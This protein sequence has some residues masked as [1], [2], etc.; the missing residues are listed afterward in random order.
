MRRDA[1]RRHARSGRGKIIGGKAIA[2]RLNFSQQRELNDST[3][4][5]RQPTV[6]PTRDLVCSRSTKKKRDTTSIPSL[7]D[8]YAYNETLPPPSLET[9]KKRWRPLGPFCIPHG[10]TYGSGPGCRPSISGRVSAIAIDPSDP[11]HILIGSGGGGGVWATRNNGK[12]WTPTSDH[13]PSLSI[14]ALSFDPTNSFVVYAGTGEGDSTLVKEKNM[15]G[16]GLLRS[17]DGGD[18]WT[19]ICREGFEQSAFYELAVDPLNNKHILAATTAGLFESSDGGLTFTSRRSQRTW[20]VSIHPV[21]ATNPNSTKEIFA[22]CSDG[23]FRSTN[24]GTAWSRVSLPGGQR[25]YERIE[26]CHAP[27]DGNVVYVFATSPDPEDED[28]DPIPH[29]WRRNV[30][31]GQFELVEKLP[32]D[33]VTEQSWYDW[34][35]AVAPNNPDVLYV[36]AINAHK[37]IRSPSGVWQWENISARKYT[38]SIHPDMHVISF[39]PA[40]PNVIYIGCDGGIFRSPD[41]GL[42]WV[43][44]NKGLCLTEVEFLAQ[45]PEFESWLIAGTQDNGTLQYQGN[46]VWYHISDGD[47]GDCGVSN[48]FPYMCYV[49]FY[50]MGVARSKRGGGWNTWPQPPRELIGPNV[51]PEN[52]YPNGA[53]FYAPLEVN[54]RTVVQAGKKVCISSNGGDDWTKETLDFRPNELSSALC[55][56]K[57]TRI[58]V[59]TT[60]GRLFR[61]DRVGQTWHSI[62]L[63]RPVIG[64]VSDILVDPTDEDKIFITFSSSKTTSHVF[65]S[66]DGGLSWN[67]ISS[68]LPNIAVNALEID[69]Q[70]TKTI[71]IGADLGLYRSDDA[72][73]TWALFNTG[74]PNVL[75]KDLALHKPSRLLRAGTQARGVWEIRIDDTSPPDVEIYLRDSP[76]DTGR[77]S[78]SPF[79]VLDPFC[80]RAQAF[81]WQCVDIKVDSSSLR[82]TLL[83]DLDFEIF[84]DD[85]SMMG[86]SEDDLGIQFAAGL[87]PENPIR[88][89][90]VRVYV[91][92]NNRGVEPAM[93]VSVSVYFASTTSTA[94]PQLPRTFWPNFPNNEIGASSRWQRVDK[95]KCVPVIAAASSKIVGFDWS[96]PPTATDTIALLSLISADNDPLTTNE[97]DVPTLIT[98]NK[99]CGLRNVTVVNPSPAN[100]PVLRAVRL[101]FGGNADPGMFSLVS[102]QTTPHVIRAVMLSKRLAKLARKERLKTTKLSSEDRIELAKLFESDSALKRELETQVVFVPSNGPLFKNV[103]LRQQQTEPM[104]LFFSPNVR[105]GAGSIMQVSEG[106]TVLGGHTFQIVA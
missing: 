66:D 17:T 51:I 11:D 34:F 57:P 4:T 91:R 25:R 84:G 6:A 104:V 7:A 44:L 106:E 54:G 9:T 92:V 50:G 53:L 20:S 13:Q 37:G 99:K 98:A 48:S 74:L 79:A 22:G 36:G 65:R 75:V 45:H 96:V 32:K 78:P 8:A 28:R 101:N 72:G 81:W 63:K 105:G 43:S 76:V 93:N 47:G 52:D 1:R 39:S 68:G 41:G 38:T 16:I 15:L 67:D 23:V 18:S 62:K 56:P 85:Q 71:F 88:N 60:R 83:D 97:L 64:N 33:L 102:T 21:V 42:D 24:G 49:T 69:P 82:T 86:I 80:F 59:G 55:I 100:G 40:N 89:Q 26:V 46:E 94:L 3:D 14:G 87:L 27:S 29:L 31:D 103:H 95:T 19:V 58:F 90:N 61:L 70:N 30:F 12:F 73:E 2:R 77:T 35:A 10:Q 5:Q